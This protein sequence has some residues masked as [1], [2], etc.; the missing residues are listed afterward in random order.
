MFMCQP[1]CFWNVDSS[2]TREI[3]SNKRIL[4]ALFGLSGGNQFIATFDQLRARWHVT[5]EAYET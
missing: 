1:V 2:S 5:L 4:Q 3:E